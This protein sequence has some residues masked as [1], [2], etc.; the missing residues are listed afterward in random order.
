MLARERQFGTPATVTQCIETAAPN[1][2]LPGWAEARATGSA[3]GL[4]YREGADS[5]T[6]PTATPGG[7]RKHG[8]VPDIADSARWVVVSLSAHEP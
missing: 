1:G 2:H 4:S 7:H 8:P 5:K 3:D 6:E